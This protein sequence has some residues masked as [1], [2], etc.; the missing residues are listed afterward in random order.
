MKRLAKNIAQLVGL[1]ILLGVVLSAA[2]LAVVPADPPSV[3]A[4]MH[5]R[6]T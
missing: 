2:V 6:V 5:G 4:A 1:W 3:D